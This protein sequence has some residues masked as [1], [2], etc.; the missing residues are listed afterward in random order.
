LPAYFRT[1]SDEHQVIVD[2][3]VSGEAARLRAAIAAHQ[4]R[5]AL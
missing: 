3:A 1:I 4:E 2:A 5:H